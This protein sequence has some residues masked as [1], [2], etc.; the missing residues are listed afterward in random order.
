MPFFFS[1][2]FEKSFSRGATGSEKQEIEAILLIIISEWWQ[3]SSSADQNCTLSQN[4]QED[5]ADM[6]I[7]HLE[8]NS[9]IFIL[10]AYAGGCQKLHHSNTNSTNA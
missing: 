10:D 9:T 6:I 8:V 4:Q 3:D 2:R 5:T 1:S 7:S